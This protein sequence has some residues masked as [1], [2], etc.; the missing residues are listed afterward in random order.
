MYAAR[1]GKVTIRHEEKAKMRRLRF[2]G[3]QPFFFPLVLV[4]DPY[5]T[6]RAASRKTDVRTHL[7]P[8]QPQKYPRPFSATHCDPMGTPTVCG[9]LAAESESQMCWLAAFVPHGNL[10]GS[11]RVD[12][13]SAAKTNEVVNR[14]WRSSW[15]GRGRDED[16][17]VILA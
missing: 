5:L 1:K 2:N 7:A 12:E 3:S 8:S 10:P 13:T 14:R 16:P 11:A 15:R 17:E 4:A 9:E 6:E